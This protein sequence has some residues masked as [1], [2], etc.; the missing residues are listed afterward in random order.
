MADPQHA[1]HDEPVLD[2]S[3]LGVGTP[4]RIDGR[5]YFVR[6][7]NKLTLQQR[8][9]LDALRPRASQLLQTIRKLSAA[10]RDELSDLLKRS[11]AIVLDAP[12]RVQ[13][14]LGDVERIAILNV[15]I[16]LRPKATPRAT[17]ATSRRSARRSTGA[18]SSRNSRTATAVSRPSTGSRASHSGSSGP[19]S[20]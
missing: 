16:H 8:M 9:D 14:A 17:G 7:P 13:R 12:A 11:C 4:I 1:S 20:G 3:T 15:F 2:I 5:R 10:E 6:H 19:T 18:S